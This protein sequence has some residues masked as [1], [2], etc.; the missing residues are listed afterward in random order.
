M[1]RN[2]LCRHLGHLELAFGGCGMLMSVAFSPGPGCDP[3]RSRTRMFR[4]SQHPGLARLAGP[5]PVIFN[6]SVCPNRSQI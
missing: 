1:A 4:R 6:R 2:D 5:Q 3:R